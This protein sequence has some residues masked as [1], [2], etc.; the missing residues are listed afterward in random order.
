VGAGMRRLDTV[1]VIAALF[2]VAVLG[3]AMGMA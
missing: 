3:F 2:L 1:T